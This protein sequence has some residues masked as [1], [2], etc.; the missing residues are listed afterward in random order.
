M[1]LSISPQQAV[2]AADQPQICTSSYSA[3]NLAYPKKKHKCYHINT[4]IITSTVQQK[5]PHH[6]LYRYHYIVCVWEV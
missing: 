2:N 6:A 5:S 3:Q 1:T 4:N